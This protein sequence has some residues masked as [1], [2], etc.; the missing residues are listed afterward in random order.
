MVVIARDDDDLAARPESG[1]EVPEHAFRRPERVARR[2]VAKLEQIA[3]Q[4]QAIDLRQR[5]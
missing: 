3:E 1:R 2:P 4:H 5:V